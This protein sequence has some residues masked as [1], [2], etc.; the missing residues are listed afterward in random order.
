MFKSLALGSVS[1]ASVP[2][3][4]S[5]AA[6]SYDSSSKSDKWNNVLTK[7][8]LEINK[9]TR[10]E[11]SCMEDGSEG[12]GWA[13]F[14]IG[15]LNFFGGDVDYPDHWFLIAETKPKNLFKEILGIITL[16]SFLV[17]FFEELKHVDTKAEK[18]KEVKK[19][20]INEYFG[21]ILK[22]IILCLDSQNKDKEK[23]PFKDLHEIYGKEIM[24]DIVKKL[25]DIKDMKDIQNLLK[26]LDSEKYT[27]VFYFL[28]E[29]G[30]NGKTVQYYEK[31]GDILKKENE[32]Y[33][34]NECYPKKDYYMKSKT[35]IKDLKK[36]VETLSDSYN[37]IDDNCQDF[38]RNIL[39]HYNLE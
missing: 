21:K 14:G 26:N 9:L 31:V 28:I 6:S 7:M 13:E 38:V 20:D 12:Q 23:N 8:N 2:A 11:I 35:T 4:K 17:P 34:D 16:G 15:V 36:Y 5:S 27:K 19:V 39:K 37:L 22:V 10:Y 25:K 30:G 18:K 33:N 32:N 24:E 29:K 1:V 3:S